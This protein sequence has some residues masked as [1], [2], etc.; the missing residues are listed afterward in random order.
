LGERFSGVAFSLVASWVSIIFIFLFGGFSL[1]LLAVCA[2]KMD[3]VGD[4]DVEDTASAFLTL[5][6]LV[7]FLFSTIPTTSSS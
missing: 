6:L 1:S 3:D 5:D 7:S 4:V 2:D